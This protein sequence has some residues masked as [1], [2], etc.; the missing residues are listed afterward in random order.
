M[1]TAY[2][3][4][5]NR[6]IPRQIKSSE[7]FGSDSLLHD[8]L[9]NSNT[10]WELIQSHPELNIG[11]Y[12][13]QYFSQTPNLSIDIILANP[14][15]HW[16]WETVSRNPRITADMVAEH[17]ELPWD[18]A[19]LSEN[20]GLTWDDVDRHYKRIPWD[21]ENLFHNV[22]LGCPVSEIERRLD[23]IPED[24]CCQDEDD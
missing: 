8:F 5:V 15:L 17:P 1:S 20:T 13:L 14:T 10:T 6:L 22:A 19:A 3:R 18:Y 24:C 4:I 21:Y 23:A 12:E 11:S 16:N 7:H 9:Q 2:E